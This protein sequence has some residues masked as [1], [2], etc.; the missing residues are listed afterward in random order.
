MFYLVKQKLKVIFLTHLIIIMNLRLKYYI[1]YYFNLMIIDNNINVI[2]NN[3]HWFYPG[4]RNFSIATYHIKCHISPS[5][6]LSYA[7][8]AECVHC[9]YLVHI[10]SKIKCICVL[11]LHAFLQCMYSQLNCFCSVAILYL[12]RN[13]LSTVAI[14]G[15]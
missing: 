11:L 3:N 4:K 14:A 2:G 8:Y 15:L 1:F 9:D 5:P 13:I 7:I 10:F 12:L 6:C